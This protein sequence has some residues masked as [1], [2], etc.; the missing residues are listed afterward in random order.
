MVKDARRV[1][2]RSTGPSRRRRGGSAAIL[3]ER[4]MDCD[5]WRSRETTG[6]AEAE[7]TGGAA[8]ERRVAGK[9]RAAGGS[10]PDGDLG[11]A[12]NRGG[13]ERRERIRGLIQIQ[14]FLINSF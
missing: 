4:A 13:R 1:E 2:A 3:G 7:L 11:S 14:I 9:R 10:D 8:R 5:A 12:E 6:E